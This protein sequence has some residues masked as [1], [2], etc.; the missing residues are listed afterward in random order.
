MYQKYK[1]FFKEYDD[2]RNETDAVC[3]DLEKKHR[4]H[5]A[6]KKGCDLCCMDYSIFP[7]EFYAILQGLKTGKFHSD[8]VY[9]ECDPNEM[10]CI[11]LRNH[12]C[13]IYNLRPMIC[14]T[15]GLPL[16]Y[17]ND[18]GEWELSTCELN[19][20][21]FNFDEFSA[22]NTFAQDKFN[23]KLFVLNKHFVAEFK[24][25][26]YAE[27]DLIPLKKLLQYFIKNTQHE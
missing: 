7:V 26:N 16:L 22:E 14:R 15:H 23:S 27:F 5:L 6:C 24:E 13:T 1:D 10:S 25:E 20:K 4:P 12:A 2:I 18:D 21:N 19:F 9:A 17:A 3:R 8:D 11:F